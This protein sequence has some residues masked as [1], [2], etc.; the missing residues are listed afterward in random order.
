MSQTHSISVRRRYGLERVC[1][2]W[3]V[4]RA[5]VYDRRRRQGAK[6][7]VWRRGPRGVH[8]DEEIGSAIEALI[9]A[10][11]F[12]GEGYRKMWARLRCQKQIRTS[13]ERVRRIMRER[14]LQAPHRPGRSQPWDHQGTITTDRPDEMWGTDMTVT[15]TTDEGKA[16]VFVAVDHCTG[17][18]A[19]IHASRWATNYEA[20]EPIRQGVRE[21]FGGFEQGLAAGLAVRHDHGSN[22]LARDFQAELAWLGIESSPSFVRQPEG[23]GIAERFIR[24]LKENLLWVQPFATIEQLRQALLAFRQTHNHQ[25]ILARHGYRTPAEHRQRCQQAAA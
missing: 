2:V 9:A 5:T 4:A 20:L 6:T 13:E 15:V 7:A 17:E 1:R 14:G 3:E 18:C 16:N 25:W 8:S 19:G 21:Y 24:T 23:N 10:S 22:Y 12:H 11:P